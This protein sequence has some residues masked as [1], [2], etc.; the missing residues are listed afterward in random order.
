MR[1][2]RILIVEDERIVALNLQQRLIKL[3]YDVVGRAA[4]GAEALAKARDSQADLVLMDIHIEGPMD[5]VDTAMRLI[6]EQQLRVIYLTA[7]SED[8]TLE[9][10]RHTQPYG[11]LLKPFSERELHATLQMALERRAGDLALAESEERARLALETASMGSWEFAPGRSELR[12]YGLAAELLG[13]GANAGAMGLDTLLSCVHEEDRLAVQTSVERAAQGGIPC[14]IEFRQVRPGQALRWIRIV[15]RVFRGGPSTEPRLIGVAQNVTERHTAE[16]R[17]RQAATVFDET[18]EG[19][20]IL[21][22]E[23]R[24]ISANPAFTL[25]TGLESSL[26]IGREL[27]FLSAAMMSQQSQAELWSAI[28]RDK[29]WQGELR[30]TRPNGELF[31]ARLSLSA[32]HGDA[33]EGVQFVGILS[34]FT[35]LRLAQE[36]LR[37]LAHYDPLTGLPNRLLMQDRLAQALERARR[38]NGHTAVLFLDLD[39]FKRI[40]DTRGHATGDLVLREVATRVKA[41]VRSDDTASRLGGDEFVVVL[42]NFNDTAHV[43]VVAEKLRHELARPLSVAGQSFHVGTSIG[44]AMFPEDG[45]SVEQ[46]LQRADT[47]MYEAKSRGRNAYA[48]Y[49]SAMTVKVARYM[50]RDQRL[51][52]AI[53]NQELRLYYQPQISAA[54]GLCT[55]VEALIRWDHPELGLLDAPEIIPAAE[56]S[57]LILDIGRWVLHEA[58]HQARNWREAGLPPIRVAVNASPTQME[59][60]KLAADVEAA[61][62]AS[63]LDPRQLE[64]EITEGSLQTESVAVATLARIRALGVS[65][66]IDDFGTGYSCLSSLKNLPLD[67]LKIDRSFVRELPSDSHS[68]TLAET[69]LGIAASMQLKVTAEGVETHEQ[70]NFLRDR[71]CHELQGWL[72]SPA[73]EAASIPNLLNR[74]RNAA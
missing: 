12:T 13:D 71:G 38:H 17:L 44:I 66:A 16:A 32:V 56:E 72:Y 57:G 34:D 53:A 25:M 1:P 43:I 41:Q 68:V 55:A 10:A 60:G 36:A 39:H 19:L 48:F 6:E 22:G 61:L 18:R 8:S 65:V 15:A 4:S 9:R 24:L 73:V 40:N 11:Y 7:Y 64:V 50:A 67:R 30:A 14:S 74:W 70:N 29:S 62:R 26:W 37:R 21:D 35:E 59:N 27:P 42:E 54:T 31:P 2:H 47:A 5:G 28:D 52:R 63:G 3:G 45:N 33:G 20:F 49:N 69:I 51:R 46:L 23:R 58:C